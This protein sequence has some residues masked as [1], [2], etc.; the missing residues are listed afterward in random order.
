MGNSQKQK[1]VILAEVPRGDWTMYEAMRAKMEPGNFPQQAETWAEDN[2]DVFETVVIPYYKGWPGYELTDAKNIIDLIDG[3]VT[4]GLMGHDGMTMGGYGI[5]DLREESK[6]ANLAE[7]IGLNLKTLNSEIYPRLD[8]LSGPRSKQLLLYKLEEK[9]D[10]ESKVMSNYAALQ[11]FENEDNSTIS[12]F[13]RSLKGYEKGKVKGFMIGACAGGQEAIKNFSMLAEEI[14][15]PVSAQTGLASWGTLAVSNSKIGD[16]PKQRFF[17]KGRDAVG[18]TLTPDRDYNIIQTV[19]DANNEKYSEAADAVFNGVAG[20]AS[21]GR[22]SGKAGRMIG[23]KM[24]TWKS[25]IEQKSIESSIQDVRD[26]KGIDLGRLKNAF[27]EFEYQRTGF[28]PEG[29]NFYS[30]FVS[31]FGQKQDPPLPKQENVIMEDF[32]SEEKSDFLGDD[33]PASS[34]KYGGRGEVLQEGLQEGLQESIEEFMPTLI[35]GNTL[36]EDTAIIGTPGFTDSLTDSLMNFI[37]PEEEDL[38]EAD[39]TSE[40]LP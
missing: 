31:T 27:D 40:F 1:V 30:D 22:P 2:K 26:D 14:N 32:L 36:V 8:E 34:E 7:E 21:F 29:R 16:E 37:N 12:K 35:G 38:F 10:L 5:S 28:V 6:I 4:I 25:T 18:V 23:G 20:L 33:I 24:P 13:V 11:N 17:V 39:T 19:D 9:E 15:I 3:N